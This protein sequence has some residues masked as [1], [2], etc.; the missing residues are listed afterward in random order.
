M[1]YFLYGVSARGGMLW[2]GHHVVVGI[3]PGVCTTCAFTCFSPLL[4]SFLSELR[5]HMASS[6][7]AGRRESNVNESYREEIDEKNDEVL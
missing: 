3:P 6:V 5:L 1:I 2:G 7:I 4:F